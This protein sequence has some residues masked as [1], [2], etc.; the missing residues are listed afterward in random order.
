MKIET[1]R[2]IFEQMS[3]DF[4]EPLFEIFGDP[5]VMKYRYGGADRDIKQTKRRVK[6]LY[7]FTGCPSKIFVLSEM[8]DNF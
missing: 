3:L 1:E 7:A 4:T 5:E 8:I 2:L 6:Y